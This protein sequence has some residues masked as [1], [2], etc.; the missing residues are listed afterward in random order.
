MTIMPFVDFFSFLVYVFAIIVSLVKGRHVYLGKVAALYFSSFAIWSL[1]NVFIHDINTTKEIAELAQDVISIGWTSFSGFFLFFVL[2][3]TDNKKVARSIPFYI[4]LITAPALFV[5]QQC[6]G[7]M[8]LEN[9]RVHY[10]WSAGWATHSPWFYLFCLYY[11]ATMGI[12]FYLLLKY[13]KKTDNQTKKKEVVI[14]VS[15]SVFPLIAGSVV[16]VILP[17]M[18]IVTIPP[19]GNVLAITWAVGFLYIIMKYKFLQV[20][21]TAAAEDIVSTMTDA[22]VILNHKGK[23]ETINTAAEDLLGYKKEE[24]EKKEIRVMDF[25]KER[26]ELFDEILQGKQI[27]HKEEILINKKKEK[28]YVILSGDVLYDYA[29]NIGGYI[30]IMNNITE[31]KQAEKAIKE[32]YSVLEQKVVERTRELEEVRNSL[33]QR[34]TKRI[35][36]ETALKAEKEQLM[37]TLGSIGDGVLT[38]D[39]DEKIVLMNGVAESL[40]G[41]TQKD[42][43]GKKIDAVFCIIKESTGKIRKPPTKEVLERGVIAS[44]EEGMILVSKTGEEKNIDDSCAPIRDK[45]NNILG[46]VMVFRDVTDRLKMEEEMLRTQK[47]ESVSML[48]GGIAHDFNN[49]L[50]AILGNISLAKLYAKK[51]DEVYDLLEEAEKASSKAKGLTYQL[52]TFSKGR[53]LIKTLINIP[54]VIK[55]TAN[56][57]LRGSKIKKQYDIDNDIWHVNADPGQINQVIQN[58]IINAS[59]LRP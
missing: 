37:I 22:L 32:T 41:W 5:Y 46:A 31:R 30:F 40:T 9:F 13:R 39:K 52:L 42:A 20:T 54:D 24:I 58:L 11:T 18:G 43:Q 28:I 19:I 1:G 8:V 45:Q 15:T 3:Y 34:I 25:Y 57:I 27:K 6:A 53:T 59:Q 2:L 23:I 14:I 48:A 7:N 36:A 17:S 29:G 49:I 51:E 47:L 26:K 21:P 10:G 44:L 4:F 16:N 35:E 12:G 55:E 38:I 50:A 56:F 33:K